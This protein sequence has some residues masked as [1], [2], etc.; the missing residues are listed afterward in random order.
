MRRWLLFSVVLLTLGFM[1]RCD[2]S[3]GKSSDTTTGDTQPDDVVEETTTTCASNAD[4]ANA[5]RGAACIVATGTCVECYDDSTCL[6]GLHCDVPRFTCFEC[7]RDTHCTLPETCNTATHT[8]AVLPCTSD[9]SCSAPTPVCDTV[10]GLCLGCVDN[11]DCTSPATCASTTHT[12]VTPLCTADSDCPSACDTTSGACVECTADQHCILP[13]T[14]DTATFTCFTASACTSATDCAVERFTR[15]C[16]A[17][18]GT[19]VECAATADCAAHEFAKVCDVAACVE[20]VTNVDCA[21]SDF[22]AVCD[23]TSRCVECLQDTDCAGNANGTLCDL[24]HKTCGECLVDTNCTTGT[25][26]A[27]GRCGECALDID[28]TSATAPACDG[29]GTCVANSTCVGDD[30]TENG[31]DGPAGARVLTPASGDVNSVN[32]DICGNAAEDD[33]FAYTAAAGENVTFTLAWSDNSADLDLAVITADGVEL[34]GQSWFNKPE[35]VTLTHLPAGTFYVI[36]TK[37]SPRTN[38][39]TPYTLSLTRTQGVA[40]TSVA[41]CA[42]EFATQRFRGS[43]NT[44]NGA[45]EFIEGAGALP[46]GARCDTMSDCASRI[47][48]YG[49]VFTD[50]FSFNWELRHTANA[51]TRAFCV[52]ARCTASTDCS[53]DDACLLGFCMPECTSDADCP[54]SDA[55]ASFTNAWPRMVC[56]TLTGECADG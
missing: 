55:S 37:F 40:C 54:I 7:V 12:C 26:Q 41:D 45:C 22:G 10:T 9:A 49:P 17:A 20:C 46:L 36:I 14:C 32:Q 52:A 4:C 5:P 42:A 30:A 11:S 13:A 24:A 23:S 44:V 33:W 50:G 8:C 18:G 35:I 39:V 51:D 15:T 38:T 34:L 19:C 27:D 29:M 6:S 25:C 31:D 16:D 2:D 56:D 28:C 1:T 47:C 48:T 3:G 21:S 53:A 43:C